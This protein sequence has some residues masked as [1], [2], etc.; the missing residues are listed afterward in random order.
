M[1]IVL[2]SSHYCKYKLTLE[3]FKIYPITIL[4]YYSKSS[5]HDKIVDI[6]RYVDINRNHVFG[7][8][9][10]TPLRDRTQCEWQWR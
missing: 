1:N 5:N 9:K 6:C 3:R 4:Y 2:Q 8:E 7:R 10:N